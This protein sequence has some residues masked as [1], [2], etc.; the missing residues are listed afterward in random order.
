MNIFKIIREAIQAAIELVYLGMLVLVFI[1]GLWG[2]DQLLRSNLNP[3]IICDKEVFTG[4]LT[5]DVVNHKLS[6]FDTVCIQKR[7]VF[8]KDDI[9]YQEN[10]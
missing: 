5:V 8:M 1:T 4:E 10:Q 7:F 6:R 9:T 2:L 3:H